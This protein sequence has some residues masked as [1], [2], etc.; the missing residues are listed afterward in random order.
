TPFRASHAI[1]VREGV[2]QAHCE[3]GEVPALLRTRTISL[4]GF[5]RDHMLIAA[6]LA[7]GTALES[8]LEA[9]FTNE[10]VGYIHLHFA[11]PGCYAA[12]AVRAGGQPAVYSPQPE[13]PCCVVGS[14]ANAPCN[15][16]LPISL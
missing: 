15:A 16:G 13:G 14:P 2:A 10:A 11:K 4:R 6:D 12:R 8:A 5:G 9:M 7:E 1:Y 3:V